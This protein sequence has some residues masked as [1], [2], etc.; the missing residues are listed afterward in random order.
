MN[1]KYYEFSLVEDDND[2]WDVVYLNTVDLGNKADKVA[3]ATSGHL[4]ALDSN[5]NLVDSGLGPDDVGK[6]FIAST[7][8]PSNTKCFWIDT[9]NG[10][11]L[12]YYNTTSSSWVLIGS[13]WT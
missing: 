10:N 11:I 6:A 5:G 3:N 1:N 9:G 13:V 12:K 4:A 2:T 7:T 8:A